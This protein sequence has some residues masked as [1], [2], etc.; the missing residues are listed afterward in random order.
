MGAHDDH[1]RVRA[2]VGEL[3]QHRL[4]PPA[5]HLEVEDDE[6][7]LPS[8]CDLERPVTVGCHRDVHPGHL[9][10]AA[11]QQPDVRFVVTD[12]HAHAPSVRTDHAAANGTQ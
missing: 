12:Q 1:R 10:R 7:R 6:V 4:S 2:C 3:G 5:W 11:V 9:E 8:P